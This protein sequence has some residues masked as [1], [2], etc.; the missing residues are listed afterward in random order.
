MILVSNLANCHF[1]NLN[2]APF[3]LLSFAGIVRSNPRRLGDL[4]LLRT[5]ARKEME[6]SSCSEMVFG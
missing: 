4:A 1:V 5:E 6:S 3:N 2:L